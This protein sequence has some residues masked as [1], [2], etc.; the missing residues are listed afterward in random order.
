MANFT[1]AYVGIV[2]ISELYWWELVVIWEL[3]FQYVVGY[4]ASFVDIN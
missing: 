1:A 2:I 4:Q 3:D